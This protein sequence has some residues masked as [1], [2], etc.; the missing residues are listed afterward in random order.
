M[1]QG[2]TFDDALAHIK[3]N[4]GTSMSLSSI[5]RLVPFLDPEGILRVGG[6]LSNSN[7]LSEE[8]KHPAFLPSDHKVTKL[9]IL[10]RH[11]KMA[12]RASEWTISSLISDYGVIPVGGVR[13]VRFFIKDC[14]VCKI[15]HK[16][17]S[18]QL[19]APL[20]GYRIK[21]REAVFSSVSLDYAGP[22]EVKRGRSLVK[23]WVCVFV[24][25]VT[26]AVRI[27]LV[28]SLEATAFLNCLQ[29][30]LCLTGNKTHH[31]RS[32][33]ATT[34]VGAKNILT[35]QIE[36]AMKKANGSKSVQDFIKDAGIT[37]NFSVPAASHHQGT[38]ERQIRT[39]K[40]VCD[41]ILGA[42]NSKRYPSDFELLTLLREAEYI[43]NCRPLSMRA[44][45]LDHVQPLRPIDLL[46]GFMEPSDRE[47]IVGNT[48]PKDK[49]RRG[50]EYTRRLSQEWWQEWLNTCLHQLQARQKWGKVQRNFQ[51]GDLVLLI[52]PST[53]SVGRYPY[54][55]VTDVKKC[56]DNLVRA[57]TVRMADGRTRERD[58]SK[59]VLI[60]AA[61][62]LVEEAK[63]DDSNDCAEKT[64]A[65]EEY[66]G[67]I[68][69]HDNIDKEEEDA[70][71]DDKIAN[72]DYIE[73]EEGYPKCWLQDE[74]G[75]DFADDENLSNMW[76]DGEGQRSL[77]FRNTTIY[78]ESGTEEDDTESVYGEDGGVEYAVR[79]L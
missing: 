23:R 78:A 60:E 2:V 62:H 69:I 16:N 22:Y 43:M 20:P 45:G 31:L 64:G 14:F 25:N 17:R 29:R 30:F 76:C 10:D 26:S 11:E 40:E 52:D 77:I 66:I 6:R 13:T 5:R 8:S 58:I 65:G 47:L 37:W 34:F 49:F 79:E 44:G 63:P 33:C 28:E 53:P 27:E 21:P 19:M 41:G 67:V 73:K 48:S 4:Y 35:Q 15:L 24:C 1:K 57:V 12:H 68:N 42:K 46:T 74:I 51:L 59:L 54:A 55:V 7:D 9:F 61:N 36:D 56:N 72:M 39:F 18:E 50:V 32:D 75:G 38:V 70:S 3:K 71:S